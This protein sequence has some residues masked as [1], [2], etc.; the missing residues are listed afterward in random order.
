MKVKVDM[1]RRGKL[2][3]LTSVML[4][5]L[6]L[7]CVAMGIL[8]VYAVVMSFKDPALYIYPTIWPDE[9]IYLYNYPKVLNARPAFRSVGKVVNAP[10][11]KIILNS[12]I[13]ALGCGLVNT[14]V[15]CVSAYLCASYKYKYS[16]IVHTTVI[17]VM[18]I[19]IIGSQAAEL[20]MLRFINL[21][22]SWLGLLILKANFL[23]MYF[24]IFYEMFKSLPIT[25]REAATL[26]G[27][28]DWRV[29]MSV[30]MPLA[31]ATFGTILLMNFI[32]YWNDY[33]TPLLYAPSHPTLSRFLI[34]IT[35]NSQD[36]FD[37]MPVQLTTT[38]ILSIPTLL[39][40]LI[41]Q[42]KLMSNLTI[43]G[44]KG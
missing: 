26:D 11:S 6:S 19:P 33:Q 8:F 39:I 36:D 14:T 17:V 18:A 37:S 38:V 43:G 21:Y 31:S 4:A 44:I 23:G 16:K 5:I 34:E 3:P 27:A 7:Y 22:N 10:M 12:I 35:R 32:T 13:Y 29:M 15:T 24:L 30:Y 1:K 20:S 28:S 2:T 40:F 42:K 41:F 9:K 25:Y